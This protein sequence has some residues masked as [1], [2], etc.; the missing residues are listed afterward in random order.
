MRNMFDE[1]P[2]VNTT[3]ATTKTT[4]AGLRMPLFAG[5]SLR[6]PAAAVYA[7]FGLAQSL[8][9]VWALFAAYGVHHGLSEGVARAYI[10]DLVEP[11]HRATAYGIFN[12]GIGLALV[13]ASVIFGAVW[14]GLGSRW[15]FFMSAGMS[16]LAL[17]VFVASLAVRDARGECAE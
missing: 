16:L 14:D 15:A 9:A 17:L 4:K 8:R 11:E 3:N 12:T 10:A 7:G 5:A 2:S 6:G 13:P 1:L